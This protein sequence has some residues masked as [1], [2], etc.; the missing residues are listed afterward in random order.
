M[1]K[2][3]AEFSNPFGFGA[4]D[5]P[6]EPLTTRHSALG[7][8]IS[9]KRIVWRFD[10]RMAGV[11]EGQVDSSQARSACVCLA[12]VM[13]PEGPESLDIYR[14]SRREIFASKPKG[15]RPVGTT[16]IV[17][18]HEVPGKASLERTVP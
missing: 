11:P 10:G 1:F 6:K 4:V 13:W 2:P 9:A 16:P 3:W 14:R 5:R 15:Q 8:P 17:A 12:S 18:W 7:L